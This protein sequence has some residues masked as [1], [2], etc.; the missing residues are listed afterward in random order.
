M[1]CL[2]ESSGRLKEQ[3]KKAKH[4]TSLAL[5]ILNDL[6]KEG[7]IPAFEAECFQYDLGHAFCLLDNLIL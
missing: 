6:S 5:D 7:K 4:E 2:A 3:I 1:K